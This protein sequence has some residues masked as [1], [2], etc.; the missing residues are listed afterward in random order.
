MSSR[1]AGNDSDSDFEEDVNVGGD[2][3]RVAAKRCEYDGQVERGDAKV[4]EEG[5][6]EEELRREESVDVLREPAKVQV[7]PL[8]L[9]NPTKEET[10][11]VPRVVL[12]PPMRPELT[13]N[14]LLERAKGSRDA[15]DQ[16][17]E[18]SVDVVRPCDPDCSLGHGKHQV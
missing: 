3:S 17:D 16:V 4:G 9:C 7:G 8:G 15:Q 12:L 14:L 13:H 1:G 2:V 11:V 6:G 18:T 5:D 10:R